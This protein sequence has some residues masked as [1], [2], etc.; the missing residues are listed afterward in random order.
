MFITSCVIKMSLIGA[1]FAALLV[2]VVLLCLRGLAVMQHYRSRSK[3]LDQLDSG[4]L[5]FFNPPSV[6]S[7]IRTF[8]RILAKGSLGSPWTHVAVVYKDVKG[9]FG[10]KNELYAYEYLSTLGGSVLHPLNPRVCRARG[11]IVCRGFVSP[12]TIDRERLDAFVLKSTES[13][14]LSSGSNALWFKSIIQR[15]VLL[16]CPDPLQGGSCADHVMKFMNAAGLWSHK[17][18]CSSVT[19][20]LGDSANAGLP[21]MCEPEVIA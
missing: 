13:T 18:F 15:H 16:M 8:L 3:P 10:P 11:R 19:D 6:P 7:C 1:G 2:G 4:H 14:R 5:L 20:L 17:H 12:P 21:P 9:I